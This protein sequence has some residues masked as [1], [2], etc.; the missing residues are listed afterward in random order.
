MEFALRPGQIQIQTIDSFSGMLARQMPLVPQFGGESKIVEDARELYR[1]A[2]RDTLRDMTAV[3]E[4]GQQLFH[5]LALHFDNDMQRLEI[6]VAGMLEKRDQWE[7]LA[8][9]EPLPLIDDLRE[10]SIKPGTRSSV[11]LTNRED[12][13]RRIEPCGCKL[14]EPR[15]IQP[16]FFTVWIT[17]SSISWSTNF[18]TVTR[19]V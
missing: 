9:R 5:R 14:W 7:F 10:L 12:R 11:Y 8:S 17:A 15:K 19:T 18:N 13:F 1:R 2:A 3:D 16:I 4:G 6:Q